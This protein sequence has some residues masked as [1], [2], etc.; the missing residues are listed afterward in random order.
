MKFAVYLAVSYQGWDGE[1]VSSIQQWK[2]NKQ[3][4]KQLILAQPR[5]LFSEVGT[6]WGTWVPT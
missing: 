1:Q 4:D 3:M 6:G 2:N 5:V